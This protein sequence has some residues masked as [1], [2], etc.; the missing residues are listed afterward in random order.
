M[1]ARHGLFPVFGLEILTV[2]KLGSK[3]FAGQFPEYLNFNHMWT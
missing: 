3:L 2:H 1:H